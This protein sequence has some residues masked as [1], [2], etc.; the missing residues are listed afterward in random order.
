MLTIPTRM[1]LNV[2]SGNN[3]LYYLRFNHASFD[4]WLERVLSRSGLYIALLICLEGLTVQ[5]GALAEL[6][7]GKW[8]ELNGHLSSFRWVTILLNVSTLERD[9]R[10]DVNYS[11]K[12]SLFDFL[13]LH[14]NY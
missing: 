10:K 11:Q 1:K 14:F 5:D 9:C 8:H 12:R 4:P 7:L 6:G 2:H 3:P 13:N